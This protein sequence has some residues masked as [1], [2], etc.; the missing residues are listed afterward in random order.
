MSV[1][2]LIKLLIATKGTWTQVTGVRS[3]MYT[4][5]Y[6]KR[7]SNIYVLKF[8]PQFIRMCRIRR[9]STQSIQLISRIISC[10]T[11]FLFFL[12]NTCPYTCGVILLFYCW[13]IYL[14]LSICLFS[15]CAFICINLTCKFLLFFWGCL[16]N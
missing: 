10:F 7:I 4:N 9:F 13:H 2:F 5:I 14:Y 12:V 16:K 15:N 6:L 8:V 11:G 1:N 3:S